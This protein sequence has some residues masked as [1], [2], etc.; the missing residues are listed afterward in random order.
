MKF[1]ILTKSAKIGN[2]CVA[3]ID[4][5]TGNKVRL[6][7]ASHFGLHG[8]LTDNDMKCEDGSYAELLDVVEV[9]TLGNEGNAYQPE[10]EIIDRRYAF[11]KI[12]RVASIIEVIQHFGTDGLS[13]IF[14]NF[15]YYV[16]E[17]TIEDV[18][19][20]LV[21][22][23]VSDLQIETGSNSE[24]K[25]KTKASFVYQGRRYKKMSVTDHNYFGAD[26][27]HIQNACIVM[28]I[29]TPV[30]DKFFKFVAAIYP[31]NT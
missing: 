8:A 9:Q 6:V 26:G 22:L 24:G 27:V 31:I 5:E 23:R 25:T 14:G 4:I 21:L 10:N 3:G 29:G 11:K 28:S 19:Y 15:G 20:S 1:L 30:Y 7:T 18:G 13:S 16:M 2:L 17:D 12:G